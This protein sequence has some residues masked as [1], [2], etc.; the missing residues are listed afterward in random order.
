MP[1]LI[2][3]QVRLALTISDGNT[4]AEEGTAESCMCV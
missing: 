1:G 4:E 3:Y 2:T